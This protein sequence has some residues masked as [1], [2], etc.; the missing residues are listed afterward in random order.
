MSSF[1]NQWKWLSWVL[2][3]I[4]V[5]AALVYGTLD[6]RHEPTAAERVSEVARTIRCPQCRGQS[7]A[8]SNV[9]VAREIRAD[10]RV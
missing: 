1:S 3:G 6:E 2:V 5:V 9:A 8:E 7:V 10:I 4:V